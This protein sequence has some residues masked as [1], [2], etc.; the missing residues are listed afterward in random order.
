MYF[1]ACSDELHQFLQCNGVLKWY[2]PCQ[3]LY[4][5]LISMSFFKLITRSLENES[6]KTKLHIRLI[7]VF[8]N[9]IS[10]GVKNKTYFTSIIAFFR[11]LYK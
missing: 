5:G 2:C 3:R 6:Q 9:S 7:I 8:D 4:K 11:S 1:C 10:R